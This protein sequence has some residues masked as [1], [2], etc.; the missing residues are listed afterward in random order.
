[1]VKFKVLTQQLPGGNEETHELPS[2]DSQSSERDTN[3]ETLQYE[4]LLVATSRLR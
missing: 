2:Q 3:P 4:G 1:M